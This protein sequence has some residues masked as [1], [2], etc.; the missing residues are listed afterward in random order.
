MKEWVT[1]FW[2]NRAGFERT[3]RTLAYFV[4][5]LVMRGVIPTGLEGGGDI[6]GP[7]L[8][9]GAFLVKAGDKNPTR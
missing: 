6:L 7:L 4:G 8:M 5:L 9:G 3:M 2:T 1:E